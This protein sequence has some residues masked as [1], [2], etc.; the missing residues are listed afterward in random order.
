M[1]LDHITSECVLIF[2]SKLS[3]INPRE[4]AG[5]RTEGE[6]INCTRGW[7]LLWGWSS[8]H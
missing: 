7:G 8:I 4:E 1:L 2:L 5:R 3:A 6:V